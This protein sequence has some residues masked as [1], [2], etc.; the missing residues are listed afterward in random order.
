MA[1]VSGRRRIVRSAAV[2]AVALLGFIGPVGSA[3]AAADD[4][5]S[6]TVLILPARWTVEVKCPVERLSDGKI[7]DVKYG[8]GTGSTRSSAK[9][10]ALKN[11]NDQIPRGHRAHHCREI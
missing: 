2:G 4:S 7:V 3:P 6:S 5:G 8:T 9:K 10:N 1:E 11:A